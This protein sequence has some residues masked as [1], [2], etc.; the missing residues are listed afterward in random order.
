MSYKISVILPIFNGEKTI[1]RAIESVINQTIGFENIELIL[2]DDASTDRSREIILDY[3]KEY[4]NIV[5]ILSDDNSGYPGRGRNEGIKRSSADF[6]MF[7]DNDDEYRSDFCEKLYDAA[8]K[9]DADVVLCDYIEEDYVSSYVCKTSYNGEIVENDSTVIFDHHVKNLNNMMLWNNL[10][11]KSIIEKNKIRFPEDKLAEDI[12]F[13]YLNYMHA[14]KVVYLKSYIGY[15]RHIQGTSLSRTLSF[16]KI[17]ESLTVLS[18]IVDEF[19]SNNYKPDYNVLFNAN[20]RLTLKYIYMS[21]DF[22]D[23]K[24]IKK[25][26]KQLYD[27]ERKIDFEYDYAPIFKIANFLLTHRMCNLLILYLKTLRA[28]AKS[29]LIRNIYRSTLGN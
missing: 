14:N 1:N 12:Y 19:N 20:I 29:R 5:P 10:F 28:F 8:V 7:M 23:K 15:V 13:S 21:Q 16:K 18:E 11:R 4:G 27:F 3:A 26:L 25:L 6:V 24:E 2:Y 22:K 9:Y 17:E